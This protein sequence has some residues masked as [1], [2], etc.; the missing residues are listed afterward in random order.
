LWERDDLE[1]FNALR[2]E[3]LVLGVEV[4]LVRRPDLD[5][6]DLPGETFDVGDVLRIALRDQKRLAD[7]EVIDERDLLAPLRRVVHPADDRVA[8]LREQRRDDALEACVVEAGS[9]SHPFRN[10]VPDVD[11]GTLR[12]SGTGLVELLRRVRDVAAKHELARALDVRRGLDVGGGTGG[13]GRRARGLLP[14]AS[15]AGREGDGECEQGEP[16]HRRDLLALPGGSFPPQKLGATPQGVAA[17][18]VMAR[19]GAF[20]EVRHPRR[21]SRRPNGVTLPSCAEVA[22]LA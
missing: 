19:P 21:G 12:R 22:E 11:V 14:A 9:D 10:L 18:I 6:G 13:R 20:A 15:A 7:L 5:R 1:R 3:L 16:W 17:G 8:L 4:V 2:R